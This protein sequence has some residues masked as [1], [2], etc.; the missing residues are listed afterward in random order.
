MKK[1]KLSTALFVLIGSS[2]LTLV[3]SIGGFW[4]WKNYRNDKLSSEKYKI[5]AIIQTGPEKEALKTAYLA[6]LLG[7]SV[8]HPQNLYAFDLKEG[9]KKLLSSPLIKKAEIKRLPPSTLYIDYEIRKPIAY[10]ADFE[11]AGIDE[12]GYVFPIEPFF[13]PKRVPEIYLGLPEKNEFPIKGPYLDLALNILKFLESAPWEEGLQVLRID[14]SS[15]FEPSLGRREVVLTTEEE[16][17]MRNEKG[18]IFCKFPKIIRLCPKDYDRQLVNFFK[19]Q[20]TMMDDYRRQ[21]TSLQ[22]GGSFSPR[23]VDLRIPQL[24]FVEK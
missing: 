9:E 5:T 18:R 8:D 12:E 24:A 15:A 6:E 13:S 3:L 19:L 1:W 7:L 10:L 22:S 14:V 20:K 2:V 17:S 21:I 16:I 4:I 23:I 11:N